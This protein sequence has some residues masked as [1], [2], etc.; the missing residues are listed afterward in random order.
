MAHKFSKI[1]FHSNNLSPIKLFHEYGRTD[2][3]I[4]RRHPTG[5]RN[6]S[7]KRNYAV[8]YSSPYFEG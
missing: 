4:F 1:K 2:S 5:M 6:P 3:A 8:K 7:T